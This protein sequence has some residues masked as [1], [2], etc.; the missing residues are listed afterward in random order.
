[1]ITVATC[2]W[3]ANAKSFDWSR[4]YDETWVEKLYRSFA[5]NLT[6]PWRFVCFTERER[7]F[8]E[9]IEQ[10]WLPADVVPHSG[11]LVEPYRLGVP[12]IM[13]GLDTVVVGNIDHLAEYCLTADVIALSKDPYNPF[14][15]TG[16]SLTP[17][18]KQSAWKHSRD[19]PDDM[20]H[21]RK[22]PHIFIEEKFPGQV[23][24]YKAHVAKQGLPKDARIVYLHGKPK[25]PDLMHLD[26][27]RANWQ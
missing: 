18:G 17:A 20:A 8:A 27:A 23:V 26:W 7:K 25:Q 4:C 2:F 16:V 6:V 1:M 3:D 11:S 22:Q 24:S 19:V 14:A 5:R 10:E 13:V 12:M 21:M 9:P 15:C